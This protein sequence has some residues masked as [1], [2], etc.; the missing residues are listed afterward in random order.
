MNQCLVVC[1]N[2]NVASQ[3]EVPEVLYGLKDRIQLPVVRRIFLAEF[4]FTKE[5]KR[6][7]TLFN[8]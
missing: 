7:P 3:E 5:A 6:L 2:S 8:L 1:E 4:F